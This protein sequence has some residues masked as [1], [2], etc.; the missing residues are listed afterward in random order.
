MDVGVNWKSCFKLTQISQKLS[1]S[2]LGRRTPIFTKLKE[3]L[4]IWEQ[5]EIFTDLSHWS[6]FEYWVHLSWLGGY[7]LA[8]LNQLRESV[9]R[10]HL[11]KQCI[12]NRWQCEA[13]TI[14]LCI[15]FCWKIFL[16]CIQL[17]C[18]GSV[19]LL[20]HC[21]E[22]MLKKQR[23]EWLMRFKY[24]DRWC[25]THSP[26]MTCKVHSVCSKS[27]GIVVW[28]STITLVLEVIVINKVQGYD[29]II[30]I[31]IF[32]ELLGVASHINICQ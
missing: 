25:W 12:N 22:I 24:N 6:W 2:H 16:V 10:K 1:S 11:N 5:Y 4:S 23:F 30:F 20:P 17:T 29:L 3:S 28:T 13:H 9:K 18:I 14:S 7:H 26:K 32:Q 27:V 31:V 8:A 15:S 21:Q 19:Q